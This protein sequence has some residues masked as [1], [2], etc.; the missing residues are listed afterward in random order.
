MLEK[1]IEAYQNAAKAGLN[2]ILELRDRKKESLA[3][4]LPDAQIL[5]GSLAISEVQLKK[6]GLVFLNRDDGLP[7]GPL[8]AAQNMAVLKD[9]WPKLPS[10]CVV[11]VG[12]I[13]NY[14]DGQSL[15]IDDFMRKQKAKALFFA[16]HSAWIKK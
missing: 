16:S 2:I 9:L 5:D 4:S 7:I 8:L 1:M 15:L 10:G 11:S 12:K 3:A 13:R 14:Y 6:I